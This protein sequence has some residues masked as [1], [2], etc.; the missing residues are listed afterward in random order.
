MPVSNKFPGES[1]SPLATADIPSDLPGDSLASYNPSRTR[2]GMISAAR[3]ESI[4]RRL[5]AMGAGTPTPESGSWSKLLDTELTRAMPAVGREAFRLITMIGKGGFGEVWEALQIP[6]NRTVAIKRLRKELLSELAD[7]SM[8]RS[9]QI[10]FRQEA[11]TTANLDHPNIVPVHDLGVDEDGSPLMAMKLIKGQSWDEILREEFHRLPAEDFLLKHIPILLQVTQAVAFAHSRGVIHRDLKPAQVIIGEFGEILLADWGLAVVVNPLLIACATKDDADFL[12]TPDNASNPAG[13]PAFM[14]PEQT[15]RSG[16]NL[17]YWTDVYLLGG[18]LFYLL[19]GLPPHRG[20]TPQEAFL[21]A[22]LGDVVDP[23]L[24]APAGRWVPQDLATLALAA[25]EPEIH[26][27]LQSANDFLIKLRRFLSGDSDRRESINLASA[28]LERLNSGKASYERLSACMAELNQ[29]LTLWPGNT[30]ARRTLDRVHAAVCEVA[31]TQGDLGLARMEAQ[32]IEEESARHRLLY[33]VRQRERA[34][35]RRERQRRFGF[36]SIAI[37]IAASMAGGAIA[38]QRVATER[39]EAL[40][41]SDVASSEL[42]R[43]LDLIDFVLDDLQQKLQTL[44]QLATLRPL[45]QRIVADLDK[46]VLPPG[47]DLTLRIHLLEARAEAYMRLANVENLLGNLAEAAVA[48]EQANA[49]AREWFALRPRALDSGS[50]LYRTHLLCAV[51]ATQRGQHELQASH[52]THLLWV[53]GRLLGEPIA[54]V[55]DEG[56]GR[57]AT[58][59]AEFLGNPARSAAIADMLGRL[60]ER[61]SELRTSV[62]RTI[63]YLAFA[64]N[65]EGQ[66]ALAEP[67]LDVG[68]R[69]VGPIVSGPLAAPQPLGLADTHMLRLAQSDTLAGLGRPEE[70]RQVIIQVVEVVRAAGDGASADSRIRDGILAEAMVRLANLDRLHGHGGDLES[71]RLAA[72]EAVT[73]AERLAAA[74]GTADLPTVRLLQL[75]AYEAL[76][77]VQYA[78]GEWST[79]V[80]TTLAAL[81]L[82]EVLL[83]RE[84]DNARARRQVDDLLRAVIS[85]DGWLSG[86]GHRELVERLKSAVARHPAVASRLGELTGNPN[87]R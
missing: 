27:R 60:A 50:L 32:A 75:R 84:D 76:A 85:L 55:D 20:S 64:L 17:G 54:G 73:Y 14:A 21:K 81:P 57:A 71:A 36:Y 51:I 47:A 52:L 82:M 44:D 33:A 83:T 66:P 41:A 74:S 79:A 19:T 67:L 1:S 53:A 5:D 12:P 31:L 59:V 45:A 28:A 16:R 78:E 49:R 69:V 42:K 70:A 9:L 10:S 62:L 2:L 48:A 25:L 46:A 23:R 77:K 40:V 37:L 86:F 35:R 56:L 15:E 72:R 39:A 4:G 38:F 24:A 68:L 43:S 80:E 30:E 7:E 8:A 6:L 26:K 29:A 61:R 63:E 3:M 87:G 58:N 34:V 11:L 65:E 18:M 22:R 13:T